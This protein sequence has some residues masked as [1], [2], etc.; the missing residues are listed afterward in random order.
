MRD[1]ETART[2]MQAAMTG[3]LVLSTIHARDT[4]GSIF[5]LQDLGM[6][7]YLIASAL[8][9]LV[10]QRLVRQLCQFWQSRYA[11]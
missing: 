2:A 8:Q 10:S 7:P 5:R 3:H 6:E 4:I 11:A 9:V 1:A